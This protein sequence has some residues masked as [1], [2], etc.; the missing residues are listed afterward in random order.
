MQYLV[1][2]RTIVLLPNISLPIRGLRNVLTLRTI[3]PPTRSERLHDRP[4]DYWMTQM[5]SRIAALS[6]TRQFPGHTN[7]R[8]PLRCLCRHLPAWPVP[9]PGLALHSDECDPMG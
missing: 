5:L 3:E 9:Q 2:L 8:T 1:D 7:P 4:L 6:E